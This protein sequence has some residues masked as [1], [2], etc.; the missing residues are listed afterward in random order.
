LQHTGPGNLRGTV[1]VSI[2]QV[3]TIQRSYLD[4]VLSWFTLFEDIGST[5]HNS[6]ILQGRK[7][8][9][10]VYFHS[11]FQPPLVPAYPLLAA[12]EPN[13]KAS[14]IPC[15][16]VPLVQA[17]D[18]YRPYRLLLTFSCDAVTRA[19]LWIR[20]ATFNDPTDC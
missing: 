11:L 12:C 16:F 9:P 15:K 18:L 10:L 6:I 7:I 17:S 3:S 4:S 13:Q 5:H 20:L 14:C 19:T 2:N 8:N 1:I